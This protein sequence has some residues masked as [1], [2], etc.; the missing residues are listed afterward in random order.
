MTIAAASERR[1][2]TLEDKPTLQMLSD[3]FEPRPIV[4]AYLALCA[5]LLSPVRAESGL[6]EGFVYLRDVDPSIAQD[7]RYAEANN[8]MGHPVPGYKA[9]ECILVGKAARALKRVQQALKPQG[10]SLKVYDCYRPA[11]AVLSFV[12]WARSPVSERSDKKSYYPNL[13]KPELLKQEYIASPSGHSLG[14]AVDLTLIQIPVS[15][16]DEA[17]SSSAG[18]GSCTAPQKKRAPDNSVDMGTGFDCFDELSHTAN[19]Q[20]A[21]KQRH[22]RQALVQAMKAEGFANY[23]LEWWHFSMAVEGFDKHLDFPVS[24]RPDGDNRAPGT[25]GGE[26]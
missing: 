6:P 4:L 25:A 22:W 8:F 17:K 20:I 21:P 26:D 11:R 23:P 24:P 12:T 14:T 16:S 9:P 10:L 13:T 15:R 3:K 5:L 19:P 7:I 1:A 18:S 2:I